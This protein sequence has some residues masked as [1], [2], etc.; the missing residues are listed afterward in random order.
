MTDQEAERLVDRF[1]MALNAIAQQ[2]LPPAPPPEPS[3]ITP[4]PSSPP[5]D[6]LLTQR[7]KTHGDF[8][9]HAMV[10]QALKRVIQTAPNWARLS[11]MQKE[12]LEMNAHKIGR[13]LAGDPDHPD[14]WDD[15]AGY[16]RLIS[17]R[18]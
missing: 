11:D 5:T 12:S 2:P 6:E 3:A 8:A 13:I 18:L 1:G 9:V 4:P 17:Q 16:A 7:G 15:I 14:H 10:T